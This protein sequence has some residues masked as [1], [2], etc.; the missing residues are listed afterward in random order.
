[1][2]KLQEIRE[3]ISHLSNENPHKYCDHWCS[4]CSES[5]KMKCQLYLDEFHSPYNKHQK[6]E[7]GTERYLET[8]YKYLKSEMDRFFEEMAE[9]ADLI[10]SPEGNRKDCITK[11]VE[12]E[13]LLITV[14]QFFRKSRI[15][16]AHFYFSCDETPKELERHFQTMSWYH[17][18]LPSKLKALMTTYYNWE[19]GDSDNT[20]SLLVEV[21]MHLDICQSGVKRSIEAM[22]HLKTSFL[23]R[24]TIVPTE[25][26][27]LLHNIDD[28]LKTLECQIDSAASI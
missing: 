18:F 6:N 1:M 2:T 22:R 9:D 4:H 15:F 23:C 17:N 24:G 8:Q 3:E 14:Q 16:L 28:R 13:H 20:E 10:V 5:K 26:L 7:L 12:K 11:K 27:A 25:I 19:G 21:V